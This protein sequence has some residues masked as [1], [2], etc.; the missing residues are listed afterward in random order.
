LKVAKTP[1]K[2]AKPSAAKPEKAKKEK[3]PKEPKPL[4]ARQ[5]AFQAKHAD[6]TVAAKG[7]KCMEHNHGLY[8]IMRGKT[9]YVVGRMSASGKSFKPEFEGDHDE[10]LEYYRGERS[11][12]YGKTPK[13]EGKK[14]SKAK[15]EKPVKKNKK[16]KAKPAEDEDLED[17]VD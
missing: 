13:G 14:S 10:A 3:A 2:K 7:I 6:V 9:D 17:L 12:S 16:A 4:S 15:A 8:F 5:K 11:G 1:S